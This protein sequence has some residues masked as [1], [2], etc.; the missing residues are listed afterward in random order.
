V[1]P[2]AAEVLRTWLLEEGADVGALHVVDA[3]VAWD[4]D[5]RG[6]PILR[7][8]VTLADPT[9]ETW[10]IGDVLEF[11]RRVDDRACELELTAPWYVGLES[12]TQDA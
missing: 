6:E 12:Q 10:P 4:E 1:T 5:A 2:E 7:F 8:L 3:D 9:D 11:H